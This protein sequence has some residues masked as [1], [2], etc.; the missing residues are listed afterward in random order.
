MRT[1]ELIDGI[2]SSALGFGCAPILGSVDAK[3]ARRALDIAL[4]C[5]INHFDL[6]RSYGYG[7][8]ETFVGKVVKGRRNRVVLASKFGIKVSWKAQLLSPVKPVVRFMMDTMK[9]KSGHGAKP[10]APA[11]SN[12]LHYRISLTGAEMRKSLEQS[13]Q[14]LQT[15]FLDYYFI[16]EPNEILV[17]A[18]EL[19]FTAEKLKTE[20][21]IRGWGIAYMRAEKDKFQN[22][23][24]QFDVQQFDNSPGSVNYSNVVTDRGLKPNILFSPLRGGSKDLSANEKLQKLF[25]DF[26]NSVVLCSMFNE[27]HI[28]ENVRLAE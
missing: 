26:P 28:K 11:I 7:K 9:K 4:D 10:G 24:N 20:G 21:K 25:R 15:D 27:Q 14:A 19:K 18:E 6:A 8:A 22:V 5:G 23:L 12:N 16:H 2:K 17:H 1:V 13:L 3:K